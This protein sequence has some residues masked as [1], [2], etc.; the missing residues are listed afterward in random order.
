MTNLEAQARKDG[1]LWENNSVLVQLLGLSP[2]LA[3]STSITYGLALGLATLLVGVVSCATVAMLRHTIPQQWRLVGFMII[4]AAY[5]SIIETIFQLYFYSLSLR[6]GIYLPLIC[7]NVAILLRME[8]K[9]MHSDLFSASL[10]ALKMGLGFL[11]ALLLVS[12]MREMLIDGSLLSDSQLL[13]PSANQPLA[14]AAGGGDYLFQF[15]NSQ[16]GALI[17]LGLIVAAINALTNALGGEE[18]K[19]EVVTAKRARVTG[20]L[21]GEAAGSEDE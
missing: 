11:G 7:C 8:T 5:T 19:I 1:L 12:A 2:V 3:V 9:A 6:L 16:P 10:D 17:L 18:N 15:A 21:T 14:S 13:I 20:R 4:L